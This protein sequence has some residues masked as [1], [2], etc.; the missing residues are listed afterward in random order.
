M[1]A[2]VLYSDEELRSIVEAAFKP[3][4][5]VVDFYDGNQKMRFIVLNGKNDVIQSLEG[6]VLRYLRYDKTLNVLAS[7]LRTVRELVEAKEPFLKWSVELTDIAS[8]TA[9]VD[10]N[11]L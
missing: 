9:V 6:L 11:S 10:R 8:L 3:L 4:R 1:E 7:H 2:Q 5:C